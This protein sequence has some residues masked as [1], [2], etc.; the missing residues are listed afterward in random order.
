M[1]HT[2][3][4]HGSIPEGFEDIKIFHC[5]QCPRIFPTR[6]T[7]VKHIQNDHMGKEFKCS[8]C[9]KSFATQIRL[10]SHIKGIHENI[11]PYECKEKGCDRTFITN[12]RLLTHMVNFHQ[13]TESMWL[14]FI[15]VNFY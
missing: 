7:L 6:D 3:S 9:P 4:V 5:D 15:L 14:K 1:V 2:K 10:R 13:R 8:E 11:R 12:Q